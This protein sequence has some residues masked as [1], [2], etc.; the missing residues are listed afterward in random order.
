VE[1]AMG[2]EEQNKLLKGKLEG[3][4]RLTE[5]LQYELQMSMEVH[6]EELN[7]MKSVTTNLINKKSE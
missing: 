4:E 3:F 7:Q 5:R 6:Q 2:L 1:K